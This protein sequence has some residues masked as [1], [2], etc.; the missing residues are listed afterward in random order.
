MDNIPE[1]FIGKYL[2]LAK[3]F[4]E[5]GNPCYSRSIGCVYVD[6]VSN[7]VAAMGYNGPPRGSKHCTD[8]EFL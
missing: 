4:G 2:R 8:P 7:A 6:P 3:Q 5:D 1:K